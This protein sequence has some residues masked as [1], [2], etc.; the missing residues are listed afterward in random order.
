MFAV[1]KIVTKK[2][3]ARLLIRMKKKWLRNNFLFRAIFSRHRKNLGRIWETPEKPSEDP[4]DPSLGPQDAWKLS[5][6]RRDFPQAFW[7][8][9][10]GPG[11]P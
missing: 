6:S 5:K 2:D 8:L 10:M 4:K 11:G 7:D 1:R 3:A 9:R